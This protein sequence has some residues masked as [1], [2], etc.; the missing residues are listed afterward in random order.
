MTDS[1]EIG[2][3]RVSWLGRHIYLNNGVL[4]L[5]M[6]AIV[7]IALWDGR[8]DALRSAKTSTENLQEMVASAVDN[9]LAMGAFVVDMT[10]SEIST[11]NDPSPDAGA[12]RAMRLQSALG[13]MR[14]PRP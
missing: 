1:D 4:L 3:Q 7:L 8:A 6:I 12:R 14:G 11:S 10:A 13:Q 9:Y 5:S 2:T